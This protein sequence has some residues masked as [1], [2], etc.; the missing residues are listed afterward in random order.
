MIIISNDDSDQG[1]NDNDNIKS[2]HGDVN[3]HANDDGKNEDT[4][5]CNDYSNSY[6][7][8]NYDKNDENDDFF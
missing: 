1:D 8:H 5:R 7:R 3:N 2:P 6:D 4:V